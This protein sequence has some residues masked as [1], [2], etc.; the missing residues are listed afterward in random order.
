[1]ITG[2]YLVIPQFPYLT[3]TLYYVFRGVG[4]FHSVQLK[5]RYSLATREKYPKL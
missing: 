5:V 3:I 4:L 2:D 1:M